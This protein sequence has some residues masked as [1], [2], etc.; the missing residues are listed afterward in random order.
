MEQQVQSS[1]KVRVLVL[2]DDAIVAFGLRATLAQRSDFQVL[3]GT[4]DRLTEP[5][6][7]VIVCDHQN[8]ISI[9]Q[10]A[11]RETGTQAM[12]TP[13]I[14]V[15]GA[16]L[17]DQPVRRALQ[18]GIHG[19]VHPDC[20]LD[21][22]THALRCV[23]SGRRFVSTQLAQHLAASFS[24][25]DLTRRELD[26]LDCLSAGH[27]NKS[28]ARELGIS[29]ATVKAHVQ[30]IMTKLNATSR[31]QVVSVALQRGFVNLTE[32]SA[33]AAPAK[34]GQPLTP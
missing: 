18:A 22:L 28:I 9:A 26:V 10:T 23:A 20:P 19:Y 27:C 25:S 7:D 12:P 31:T 24:H 21:E 6:S 17:G 14:L 8:G 1:A 2:H 3:S 13:R 11:R 4:P 5:V 30:A 32:Q 34:A 29:V 16:A 33:A 15:Y